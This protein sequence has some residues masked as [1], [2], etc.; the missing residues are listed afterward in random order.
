MPL[1]QFTS[2]K[3]EDNVEVEGRGIPQGI[4]ARGPLNDVP[5]TDF[6]PPFVIHI[7]II[8]NPPNEPDPDR[9][10]RASGY[11]TMDREGVWEAT[12]D[13]KG[14]AFDR[15]KPARGVAV[16]VLPRKQGY[17]SEVLTWCDHLFDLDGSETKEEADA[18]AAAQ[19]AA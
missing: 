8:Q 1:S 4:V 3:L 6:V 5:D 18:K 17:T 2:A 15:T 19:A 13:P 7:T 16:A 14:V 11:T 10:L 12:I 9:A